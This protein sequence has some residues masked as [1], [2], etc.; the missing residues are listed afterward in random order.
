MIQA[1]DSDFWTSCGTYLQEGNG[2]YIVSYFNDNDNGGDDDDDDDGG[3]G[4]GGGDYDDDD[5]DDVKAEMIPVINGNWN[6]LK[7][8]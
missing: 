4:G 2:S 1:L 3:G 5:N 7:I 8:I 6:L